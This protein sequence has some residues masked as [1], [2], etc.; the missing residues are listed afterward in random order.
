MAEDQQIP[1]L[2]HDTTLQ[3]GNTQMPLMDETVVGGESDS[4]QPRASSSKHESTEVKDVSGMSS[5]D[6]SSMKK[7]LG[8]ENTVDTLMD[9]T[10]VS[11]DPL[12]PCTNRLTRLSSSCL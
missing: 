9:A 6:I 8:A 7:T 1:T 11:L 3:G 12:F 2:S 5:D 4:R 10:K